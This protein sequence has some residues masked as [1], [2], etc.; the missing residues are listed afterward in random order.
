MV[1]AGS[2]LVLNPIQK[3]IANECMSLKDTGKDVL[4]GGTIGAITGPIGESY[5]LIN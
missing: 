2:S 5:L 3:T 1:G 4:L